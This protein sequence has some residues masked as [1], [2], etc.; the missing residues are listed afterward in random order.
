M[1]K[2]NILLLGFVIAVLSGCTYSF[3]D[4]GEPTSGTA[5]FTKVVVVGNS[6]SAGFMDGALYDAGQAASYANIVAQQ[7]AF[8]GGGDFNQPDINAEDGIILSFLPTV[9][10]RLILKGDLTPEGIISPLPS[11]I[12][13]GNPL[14]GY[15]GDK[16]QLNNLAVPGMRLTHIDVAGFGLGNPYYGRFARDVNTSSVLSDALAADGSFFFFWLG[17]NDALG[18]ASSGAT[19]N[20]NGDG[21]SSSDLTDATIFD[22]LYRSSVASLITDKDKKGVLI[23]IPFVYDVAYFKTVTWNAIPM[24]QATADLTNA[25]L[26]PVNDVFDALKDPS[27]GLD[28][29]DLEARKMTFAAGNNP[30]TMQDDKLLD[31]GPY[32]DTLE[33]LGAI[34]PTER[35][36]L[37]PYRQ[38]RPMTSTDLVTLDAGLVLGTLADPG[39]PA[40]VIGVAVPLAETYSLTLEDQELLADRI[41]DYNNT[42]RSVAENSDDLIMFDFNDA[43]NE[44]LT[45]NILINGSGINATLFPPNGALSLDG[46]HP[47]QR[48]SAYVASLLID[49]I[50]DGFNSTIPNINPNDW[51]GNALPVPNP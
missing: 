31:L 32:F 14:T 42:I 21:T 45:G 33:G 7:M 15:D 3:P 36:L 1:K 4:P 29:D 2:L 19:G 39:N 12:G 25:A 51:P 47:N 20:E 30:I 48:G 34:S 44:L 46:I 50:N 26:Q 27:F 18:Y 43:Y 24:D 41:T 5:D 9:A 8:V 37:E 6:L 10:G 17:G 40:T 35:A 49:L 22:N 11:P 38:S 23:N 16:T 13:P 28:S